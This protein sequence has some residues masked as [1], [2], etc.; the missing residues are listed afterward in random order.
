M[1]AQLISLLGARDVELEEQ[2]AD[3]AG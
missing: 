3:A 2:V 1:T